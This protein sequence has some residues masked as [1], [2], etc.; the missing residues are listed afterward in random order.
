MPLHGYCKV[1]NHQF[2]ILSCTLKDINI[3]SRYTIVKLSP[4]YITISIMHRHKEGLSLNIFS[5][6]ITISCNWNAESIALETKL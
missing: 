6:I 1:T 4:M 3:V 2:T 5:K